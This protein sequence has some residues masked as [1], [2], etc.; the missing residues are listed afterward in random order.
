MP[1]KKMITFDEWFEEHY[2]KK[3]K[4]GWKTAIFNHMRNCWNAAQ[5]NMPSRASA[6]LQREYSQSEIDSWNA[7]GGS[8]TQDEI[9]RS[10]EWR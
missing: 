3:N 5:E 8:F 9:K 10:T 4:C 1:K 2:P 6:H 7:Q